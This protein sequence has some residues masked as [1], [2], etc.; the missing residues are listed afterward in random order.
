MLSRGRCGL[1]TQ[2]TALSTV[3]RRHQ[4][5]RA[6][7]Q[8]HAADAFDLLAALELAEGGDG[9]LDEVLGAGRAVGFGQ[10]VGDAGELDARPHALA[11]GDAGARTGRGEDDAAGAALALDLVRDGRALEVHLEHAL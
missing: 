8:A 6:L 10:D 7:R 4:L 3:L 5:P 11:R 1:S 9:G 2:H